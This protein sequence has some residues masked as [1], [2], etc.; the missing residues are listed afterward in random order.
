MW[1][2]PWPGT[3]ASAP[4]MA[5]PAGEYPEHREAAAVLGPEGELS[6]PCEAQVWMEGKGW[7]WAQMIEGMEA[8]ERRGIL[9]SRDGVQVASKYGF[10]MLYRLQL[11]SDNARGSMTGSTCPV[12]GAEMVATIR[13]EEGTR[14]TYS[15]ENRPQVFHQL[16]PYP[17]WIESHRQGHRLWSMF[18]RPAMVLR[19]LT[20][21]WGNTAWKMQLCAP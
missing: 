14:A 19:C 17:S 15:K 3:G 8:K 2:P 16:F 21:A 10:I 1:R 7:L 20:W 5:H 6:V 9:K 11:T 12:S 4:G 13:T 18:S